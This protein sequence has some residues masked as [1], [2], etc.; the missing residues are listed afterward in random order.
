VSMFSEEVLIGTSAG[1]RAFMNVKPGKNSGYDQTSNPVA[2]LVYSDGTITANLPLVCSAR[3]PLRRPP[4]HGRMLRSLHH[5]KK[6]THQPENQIA[7][8]LPFLFL[9]SGTQAVTR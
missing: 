8:K 9:L 5:H 4:L 2:I 1:N 6:T 3:I 7:P